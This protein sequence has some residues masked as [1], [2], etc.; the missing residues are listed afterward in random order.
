MKY[1]WE[2]DPILPKCIMTAFMKR[3]RM[4]LA[5]LP[6]CMVSRC[7]CYVWSQ[8]KTDETHTADTGLYLAKCRFSPITDVTRETLGRHLLQNDRVGPPV[9][10]VNPDPRQYDPGILL[11]NPRALPDV[12]EQDRQ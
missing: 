8:G 10:S 3:V 7:S 2:D 5:F 12:T 6:C 11:L 4:P 9:W 1:V